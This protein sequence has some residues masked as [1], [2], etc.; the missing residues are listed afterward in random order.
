[1][2]HIQKE[3]ASLEQR[4]MDMC[5]EFERS[6]GLAVFGIYLHN[7]SDTRRVKSVQTTHQSVVSYPMDDDHAH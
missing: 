6:T 3:I 5:T 4:I 2:N 7:D 1:M